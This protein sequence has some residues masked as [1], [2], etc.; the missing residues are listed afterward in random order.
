M[1]MDQTLIHG[2]AL[3]SCSMAVV[4]T[5]V[6]ISSL[7]ACTFYER[8]DATNMK[9]YGVVLVDGMRSVAVSSES[10]IVGDCFRFWECKT[11]IP[12]CI[13]ASV[14]VES[15]QLF[16]FAHI[17]G[18]CTWTGAAPNSRRCVA[19]FRARENLPRRH[20]V[21]VRL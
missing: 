11:A 1:D 9:P 18:T 7:K 2:R 19:S 6:L 13:D 16:P 20:V 10:C 8:R 3:F 14:Y 4:R 15:A 5:G 21:W 12:G 17:A